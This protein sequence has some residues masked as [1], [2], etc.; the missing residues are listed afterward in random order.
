MHSCSTILSLKSLLAEEIWMKLNIVLRKGRHGLLHWWQ[1]VINGERGNKKANVT[2]TFPW[3]SDMYVTLH[4]TM[5][6]NITRKHL[7]HCFLL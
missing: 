4:H 2:T 7:Q 6:V 5:T 3:S 1:P